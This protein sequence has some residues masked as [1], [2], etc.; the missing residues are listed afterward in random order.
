ML[1]EVPSPYRR[2]CVFFPSSSRSVADR[3]KLSN[4]IHLFFFRRQSSFLLFSSSSDTETVTV[5][6][7]PSVS[8]G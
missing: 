3:V 1:L 4:K 2:S 7:S 6:S 8:V 5:A